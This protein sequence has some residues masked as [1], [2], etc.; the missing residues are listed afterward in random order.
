MLKE[1]LLIVCVMLGGIWIGEKIGGSNGIA[2]VLDS[3][4]NYGKYHVY[5]STQEMT[6]SGL[7]EPQALVPDGLANLYSKENKDKHRKDRK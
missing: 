5:N 3:C 7:F 4:A 2:T 1:L 6:C